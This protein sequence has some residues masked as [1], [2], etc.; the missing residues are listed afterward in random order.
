MSTTAHVVADLRDAVDALRHH[1]RRAEREHA[2][3]AAVGAGVADD[4]A[5]QPDD[6]AVVAEP[7][8]E[9]LHLP[10]AVR[11]RDHVLGAGLDPLHRPAELERDAHRDDVLRR[12]VLGAERTADV[13][14]DQP[15]RVGLEAEAAG[16][17]SRGSMCGIWH[18]E[19]HGELVTVA[20]VAGDHRD[21][22]AL[23]RHDRDAL[24]L[25][26]P[27]HDDVG[28]RERVVAVGLACAH[29]DVRADRRRTACGASG[30]SARSMSA[31]AAS[32]S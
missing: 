23:H 8:L 18:A 17:A 4:P 5:A 15:H 1:P 21:G 32:G 6:G 19:V 7:E 25:E 3:E 9:V 10:A 30:A 20:V 27:A 16:E 11:H 31:T 26:P 29:D 22:G 12:P 14:R 28:A 2:A 13:R 24:V